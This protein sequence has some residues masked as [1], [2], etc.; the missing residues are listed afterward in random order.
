MDGAKQNTDTLA[1]CI[2]TFG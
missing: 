2:C 1:A